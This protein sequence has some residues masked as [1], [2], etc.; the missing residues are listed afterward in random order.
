MWFLL[1]AGVDGLTVA[2]YCKE[3]GFFPGAQVLERPSPLE[4]VEV[5]L[6]RVHPGGSCLVLGAQEALELLLSSQE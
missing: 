3:W 2:V 1:W 6:E 4:A 5:L